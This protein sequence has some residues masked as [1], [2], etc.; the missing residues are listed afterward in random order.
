MEEHLKVFPDFKGCTK[1]ADGYTCVL[2]LSQGQN[3]WICGHIESGFP[4]R[5]MIIPED[6]T[7]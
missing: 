1:W 4:H 5:G 7:R 6:Q 3:M 2:S